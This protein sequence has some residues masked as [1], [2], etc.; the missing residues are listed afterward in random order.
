MYTWDT[1]SNSYAVHASGR[2]ES[3]AE[4]KHQLHIVSQLARPAREVGYG[5][6]LGRSGLHGQKQV[7]NFF[8]GHGSPLEPVG[9]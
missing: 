9:S 6:T 3:L 8:Y 4:N 7:I 5:R 1:Y 2:Q